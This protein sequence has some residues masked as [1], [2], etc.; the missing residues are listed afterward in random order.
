M[1]TLFGTGTSLLVTALI[2]AVSGV[3]QVIATSKIPSGSNTTN[4][5]LKSAHTYA[6]I[7]YILSFVAAGLTLILA[8]F[9]YT[10]GSI[11]TSEWPHLIIFILIAGSTIASG[12]LALL[13]INDVNDSGEKK[14][15]PDTYLWISVAMLAAALIILAISGAWRVAHNTD[16]DNRCVGEYP[17][18]QL[19]LDCSRNLSMG[20]SGATGARP[21]F[22]IEDA[23]AVTGTTPSTNS[24]FPA[25]V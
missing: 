23:R 4:E 11:W 9:Y 21:P 19:P 16:P 17:G 2:L 1:G 22:P 8:I 10:H 14:E 18:E 24:L 5:K 3:L 6:L 20:T 7:S 13:A 25:V 15:N 12:I